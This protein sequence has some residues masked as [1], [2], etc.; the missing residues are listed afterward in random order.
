VRPRIPRPDLE[1]AVSAFFRAAVGAI[2]LPGSSYP[3]VRGVRRTWSSRWR[4]SSWRRSW[5]GVGGGWCSGRD[6]AFRGAATG[7]E[8]RSA[9]PARPS[10]YHLLCH[11]G[12]RPSEP[13][14]TPSRRRA[15]EPRLRAQDFSGSCAVTRRNPL[16]HAGATNGTDSPHSDVEGVP[17]CRIL[18][19]IAWLDGVLVT[20]TFAEFTPLRTRAN[21]RIPVSQNHRQFIRIS[22]ASVT[23]K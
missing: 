4:S 3:T 21:R 19:P 14:R 22:S 17:P 9:R 23:V 5:W 11:S 18:A 15:V 7:S 13:P 8:G 12:A 2:S 10:E 1:K 6:A 16:L 20:A